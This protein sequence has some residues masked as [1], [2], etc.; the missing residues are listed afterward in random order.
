MLN[1]V[2]ELSLEV[3]EIDVRNVKGLEEVFQG[4]DYVIHLAAVLSVDESTRNPRY[5]H[6]INATGTLNV[7]IAAE[8]V[9]ISKV[10]Y[11]SSAAV[12]GTPCE[13][14]IREDHPTVP[15]SVY[16]ASKLS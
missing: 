16:G 3:L 15:T 2:R 6:E 14:P 9:G 4:S 11:A 8:K 10:I 1:R 5:Y 12:Y 7:L 13:L